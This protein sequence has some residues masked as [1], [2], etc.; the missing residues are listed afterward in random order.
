MDWSKGFSSK[1]Y[2]SVV[3][4][5][6]WRDTDHLELTGGHI[7]RNISSLRESADIST[8]DL[9]TSRE[10]WVRIWLIAKQEDDSE[11]VAL[12]TGITSCPTTKINRRKIETPIECYSVLKPAEDVLLP[13]GYYV[14]IEVPGAVEIK[15]LLSVSPAPVI[16][17]GESSELEEAII[18]ESGETNLSMVEKIL[19]AIN[20]NLKLK[21]DGT[22][23]LGPY[24]EESSM[25]IGTNYDIVEPEVEI[26]QDW[27]DC[28][29]VF[30][31]ISGGLSA[32]AMDES[33]DSIMSVQ[34][35]GREIWAEETDCYLNDDESLA[36]YAARRLKE[37]QT[38]GLSVSYSRR[39]IPNIDPGDIITLNYPDYDGLAMEEYTIESQSISL[40]KGA[41][42]SEKV[43]KTV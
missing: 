18:A 22:I 40:G 27:F 38:Y 21:G 41:Q 2:L 12:F 9:N 32:V 19:E 4:P 15:R 3:D 34:N 35:R 8:N 5:L 23:V 14:P 37:L 10:F 29:N 39:F 30:R 24:P 17:D 36:E 43:Y 11:R 42:V 7:E 20:W 26:E 16:I 31:V 1:Y 25:I 28:P 6:T 13:R 33:D